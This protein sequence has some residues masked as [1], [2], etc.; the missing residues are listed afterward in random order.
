MGVQ[1]KVAPDGSMT[2]PHDV[3]AALGLEGGG[4]L[5]LDVDDYDVRLSTV[6]QRVRKAQALYRKYS[7]G[8]PTSTVDDFIRD[9]REEAAQ[10]EAAFA[11]KYP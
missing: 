7:E 10:E 4:E 2:L 6:R 11:R 1:V 3:R 5:T 8:K 9:K